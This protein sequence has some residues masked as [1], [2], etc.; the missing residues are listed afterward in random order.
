MNYIIYYY[1]YTHIHCDMNMCHRAYGF[2][3]YA[4]FQLSPAQPI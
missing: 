4:I 3:I 2:A 1:V